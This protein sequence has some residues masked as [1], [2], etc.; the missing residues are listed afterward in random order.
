[1][2]RVMLF[3]LWGGLSLF[4]AAGKAQAVSILRDA[5]IEY[6]LKQLANPVLTAAGLG[7]QNVKVLLIDDPRLNAFVIDREHIFIHSGLVLK[8]DSAA[9]LQAV[10]S[11]EA[12]HISHGHMVRRIQAYK[13]AQLTSGFGVMLAAAVA[14]GGNGKAAAGLA[15]GVS[16]SAKGVMAGHSR[17][18][19]TAADAA[20]AAY[21]RHAGI[22][23]NGMVEVLSMFRGQEALS[24]V[25]RQD[26]WARTHPSTRDR[27]RTAQ[28]AAA[29]GYTVKDSKTADYWF[30][31]VQGKLSAFKR[32]SKWTLTRAKGQ[33]ELD[34]M[35]RAIA[36]HR[37]PNATKAAAEISA[38]VARRPNDPFVLDLQGQILLESRDINGAA[39]AMRRARSLAPNNAL[40]LGGLGRVLIAQNTAASN[41]EALPIL[42]RARTLDRRSIR[43]LRDLSTA[44]ARAGKQGHAI[45]TAG[46]AAALRGDMKTASSHAKRAAGMLPRGS[47]AWQRAQDLIVDG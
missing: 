47:A 32:G 36:Y 42:E 12:A 7:G 11:H 25:G 8:L 45:L 13:S 29:S 27:L 38:L 41:R 1:M 16:G 21:L 35:R 3:I 10:I 28:A 33:S 4:T 17:S 6:G 46:E 39:K 44:Y 30:A 20:S 2:W 34:L 18:D 26:P 23:P 5:D 31:R 19:E 15:L 9:Q 37:Q 40:I 43:I 14:A 22:D 24:V